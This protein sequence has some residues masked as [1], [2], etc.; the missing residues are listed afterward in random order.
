MQTCI[1]TKEY[2][3]V[4]SDDTLSSS[5]GNNREQTFCTNKDPV[6]WNTFDNNTPV[7]L[8]YKRDLQHRGRGKQKKRIKLSDKKS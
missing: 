2:Y 6:N 3:T 1:K 5:I 4:T 8:N 7:L